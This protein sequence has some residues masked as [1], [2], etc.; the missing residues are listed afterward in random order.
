VRPATIWVALL[1]GAAALS[2]WT[3]VAWAINSRPSHTV[4]AVLDVEP[5]A[6][7]IRAPDGRTALVLTGEAG[8][9]VVASAASQLELWE[10]SVDVVVGPGGLRTGV[11]LLTLVQP[12]PGA[13]DTAAMPQ[14]AG[15]MLA[16][17]TVVELSDGLTITVVDVRDAS[18]RPVLDLAVRADGLGVLLPGPGAPSDRWPAAIPEMPLA[19]RLPRSAVSWART[20][21][22]Q[23]WLLLIGDP[24][25][26]RARGE[27]GVPLLL[28]RE[29]GTV[30]L[31]VQSG[32][33]SVQTERCSNGH[34][35]QL[36]LP[37]A[38]YGPLLMD[39][40]D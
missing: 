11:D 4:V 18:E 32:T 22:P 38:T 24:G 15:D 25:T 5:S 31:S 40:T 2:S 27:S 16:P 8:P 1:A 19:A 26:A 37:P 28:A 13:D 33:V 21:P 12:A 9:G 20:L 10:S 7:L 14:L 6:A 3:F 30:E 17:G 29:Y 34:A 35:C 23:S 36:E 39:G